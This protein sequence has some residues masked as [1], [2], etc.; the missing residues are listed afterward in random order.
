ME[1]REAITAVVSGNNL[2][3]SEARAV[4]DK[5]MAGQA[6]PA[7]I[8]AL[9]AALRMKQ[10]SVEEIAGFAQGM[11]A[12]ARE[13]SV[14]ELELVDTCGTG[15]DGAGTFNIS[16]T[17][18]FVAAGA[19][20]KVAKHGNRFASSRCGSADVLEALGV[21]IVLK[22]EEVARCIREVGIGFLF[23]QTHHT[24]MRHAIGP[25]R[26]IGMRTVFN[27]LGPLT[28]PAGAVFQVIGV[29]EPALT[30]LLAAVLSRLGCRRALVVHG[31]DGLDELTIT[32]PSKVS[33]LNN[34]R[35]S[36]YTLDPR[37]YGIC[38]ADFHSL[39]GGEAG[40]NARITRAVLSGEH[41]AHRD[42]VALNAGAAIYVSGEVENL[43]EAI[44]KA[45][46]AIDSGAA[47][48]KLAALIELSNSLGGKSD[49]LRQNCASQTA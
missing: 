39:K 41:G 37:E 45:Q 40:T 21:N 14:P 44:A 36:N 5:I 20:V 26:E 33:E 3:E 30:D 25:R 16:T 18:A 17:A 24:A 19:G 2:T 42:I 34:G 47:L 48:S 23:A 46:V 32:G 29:F 6:T 31:S 15:G 11:L 8:G 4:M 9:L 28:N 12:A 13:V 27:L 49:V 43:A 1:L 38:L 10:E 35:I 22:P 7:Q